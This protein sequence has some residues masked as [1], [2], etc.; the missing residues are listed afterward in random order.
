[1]CGLTDDQSVFTLGVGFGPMIGAPLSETIGR[2]AVY[3][4]TG[5]LY[6]IFLMASALSPNFGGLLVFRFLAGA[7][8]GPCISITGG[9]TAD[10][11]PE[12]LRANTMIALQTAGFFGASIG[13][14]VGGY[15]A[16]RKGWRWTQWV[17]LI[18]A[19]VALVLIAPT[20]ETYAKALSKRQEKGQSDRKGLARLGGMDRKRAKEMLRIILLR[21]LYMLATEP[22]VTLFSLYNAF[23]LGVLYGFFAAYPAVF[24]EVYGFDSGQTG[25]TFLSSAIGMILAGVTAI[26]IQTK[27]YLPKHREAGDM[28]LPPESRL[29]GAMIGG[30]GIPVGFVFAPVSSHLPY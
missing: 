29:Y 10:L 3:K 17:A 20:R 22:I 25:L 1:M 13:P 12:H 5:V 26:V 9:T 7:A 14:V 23:A 28:G 18:I 8:G 16:E 2:S 15:I 24:R 27:I 30:F 6:C 21:P 4:A 11:F 19:G